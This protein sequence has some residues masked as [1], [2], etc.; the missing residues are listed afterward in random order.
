MNHRTSQSESGGM[1]GRKKTALPSGIKL[2][3]SYAPGHI[4]TTTP[5]GNIHVP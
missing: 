5:H 3:I 1:A 2:R 4:T